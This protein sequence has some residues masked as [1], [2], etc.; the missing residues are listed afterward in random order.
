MDE[1]L[2]ELDVA[3]QLLKAR[4]PPEAEPDMLEILACLLWGELRAQRLMALDQIAQATRP[5]GPEGEIM[6]DDFDAAVA[7]DS[8]VRNRDGTLPLPPPP[9]TMPV[10][11]AKVR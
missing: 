10:P 3:R 7:E 4:M 1:M 6:G 9:G 2:R 11:G 5:R 8:L